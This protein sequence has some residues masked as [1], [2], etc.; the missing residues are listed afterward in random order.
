MTKLELPIADVEAPRK[1]RPWRFGLGMLLLVVA[2]I[3]GFL[4]GRMSAIRPLEAAR[5]EAAQ[6]QREA[7]EAV[8]EQ[9]I[10]RTQILGSRLMVGIGQ[11]V[12]VDAYWAESFIAEGAT[13]KELFLLGRSMVGETSF[14]TLL[15]DFLDADG[16][17]PG[18]VLFEGDKVV[19]PPHEPKGGYH[20]VAIDLGSTK[21]VPGNKYAFILDGYSLRDGLPSSAGFI[22]A[23]YTH[24]DFYSIRAGL[25]SRTEHLQQLF[26]AKYA[27][28]DVAYRLVYD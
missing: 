16:T 12:M 8:Q 21:L 28:R 7:F 22:G 14:R 23:D 10:L 17:I 20:V 13:V 19:V 1:I 18:R 15:I 2:V 27:D 9:L 11:D 4:A 25:G 24:G 26:K 3:C 5:R 6:A